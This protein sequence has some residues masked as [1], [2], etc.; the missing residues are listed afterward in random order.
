M[1]DSHLRRN[2]PR[3]ILGLVV[4]GLGIL[5]TLDK[6]GYVEAGSLWEY[7]PVLLIA[8]GFGR[9]LLPRGCHGRGFGL[10]LI[11]VGTLFLLNNLGLLPYRVWD[12]W[13]VLLLL[14]GVSM[15]W[16]AV[17]GVRGRGPS[18]WGDSGFVSELNEGPGPGAP[19][20]APSGAAPPAGG[21]GPDESSTVDCFALLGGS[22]RRSTS[23]DFRG[24]SL[25][26]FMGGCELDL[27]Q[28]SIRGGQQATVDAFAM[29]GGIEIKVPQ[30]W[31]VVLH[32]TPI[33][34]GFDDKTTHVGGD[35]SKV[36]VVT[37]AAVMG[38]VDI[39]N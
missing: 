1:V 22:R 31:T 24:G 21:V 36:L 14:A 2:G 18:R 6:L 23:Q 37:G 13:P 28:A 27:R 17:S 4:I 16:R 12:F 19:A 3:L 15:V 25:F 7:W 20:A 30:D 11:V 10:V 8:A 35:G 34:G 5:F 33:L 39:K 29:W 38:G 26:A 32:G 9:L